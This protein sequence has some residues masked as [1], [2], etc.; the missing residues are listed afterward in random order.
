MSIS[1]LIQ[2][3]PAAYVLVFFRVAGIMAFAPLLGSNRIPRR[4]K[5]LLAAIIALGICPTVTTP[6]VVPGNMWELAV[7]VGGELIFGIAMGSVL[8]MVFIAA[9]WAGEVIGQQIGFNM[10]QVLD[11]Q[12]G[13][14]GTI[15]G[16]LYF[17]FA[18]MV[19]LAIGGHRAM[20]DG[21]RQSFDVLPL[22][23]VGANQSVL[24]MFVGLFRG[25]TTLALQLSAPM[26]VTMLIVDLALGFISKTIP[27]M[28][29]M[30]AGMSIRGVVGMIVLIFG[31]SLT[32]DVIANSLYDAMADFH[33]GWTT[34]QL[35]VR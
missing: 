30:T 33:T 11:P 27:Q 28:N 6:A 3:V 18:L 9:Q 20:L 10:S 5:V 2:V 25:C 21:V 24:D 31:I 17:W 26:L 15:I 35:G 4:V 12:F 19:F 34:T 16:D 13:G 23:S 8:S 7:A 29:L 1:D 32:N 22:L 14:Q